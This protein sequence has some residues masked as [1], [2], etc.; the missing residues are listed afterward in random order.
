[1]PTNTSLDLMYSIKTSTYSILYSINN[2]KPIKYLMYSI[3]K[4]FYG[5]V[6]FFYINIHPP[7]KVEGVQKRVQQ[8][9]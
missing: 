9:H 2:Y 7:S 3:L 5:R 4:I 8:V 1:M 6:L